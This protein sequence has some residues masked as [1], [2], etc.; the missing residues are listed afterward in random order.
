[1][2]LQQKHCI[3]CKG[4]TPLNEEEEDAYLQQIGE[5]HIDRHLEHK[6]TRSFTFGSYPETIA[7]V[8]KIAEVAETEGHHPD[9]YI[10]YGKIK[11]ELYTH[12]M[13]GLSEND[14]ILAAK[15]DTINR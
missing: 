7:F 12:A 8:N 9:L 5:W 3:P 10:G 2:K 11:V 4:G 15:I 13:L 1:M 6:I 14:F